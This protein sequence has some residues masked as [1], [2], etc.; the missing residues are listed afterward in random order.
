MTQKKKKQATNWKKTF[1][2]HTI[3]K[4]LYKLI[5]QTNRK[6]KQ[7]NRKYKVRKGMKRYYTETETQVAHK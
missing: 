7:S 6:G 5:K 3:D 4:I 2:T 1:A